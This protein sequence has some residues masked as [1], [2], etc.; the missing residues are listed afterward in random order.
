MV[1]ST[2]SEGVDWVEFIVFIDV[3]LEGVDEEW[4]VAE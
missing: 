1:I 3:G 2:V 4:I